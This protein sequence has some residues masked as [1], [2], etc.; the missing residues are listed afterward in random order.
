M[1][2]E[3]SRPG[4]EQHRPSDGSEDEDSTDVSETEASYAY[5]SSSSYDMGPPPTFE[6]FMQWIDPEYR[7][8][9]S[10]DPERWERRQRRR[11]ELRESREKRRQEQQ[12]RREQRRQAQ[13]R[14]LEDQVAAQQIGVHLPAAAP[15]HEHELAYEQ[16]NANEIEEIRPVPVRDPVVI[17]I[18]HAVPAPAPI[19]APVHAPVPEAAPAPVSVPEAEQ[20]SDSETDPLYPPPPAE[21]VHNQ[22]PQHAVWN[23]PGDLPVAEPSG[24]QEDIPSPVIHLDTDADDEADGDDEGMEAKEPEPLAPLAPLGAPAAPVHHHH[25]HAASAA[26]FKPLTRRQLFQAVQAW[27]REPAKARI[28]YGPIQAWDVSAITDMHELFKDAIHFNDDISTWNVGAVTNMQGMF[29][30]ARSFNQSLNA[31]DVA[32]VTTMESMFEGARSFNQ[33]LANWDVAN[34]LSMDAMFQGA[35]AFNQSLLDWTPRRLLGMADMFTDATAFHQVLE[36][37][38]DIVPEAAQHDLMTQRMR[39]DP[40]ARNLRRRL[41]GGGR[42]PRYGRHG[43]ALPLIDIDPA[44]YAAWSAFLAQQ[45]R[46]Q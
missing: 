1:G 23:A 42:A 32:Q 29:M 5:D 15:I 3:A 28:R 27:L 33:P 39:V 22:P 34:V 46:R 10:H 12:E 17:P 38:P 43:D 30:N 44:E 24:E 2:N 45:Q 4:Q 8:T 31:W 35:A 36:T 14:F 6:R 26:A 9:W 7:A 40:T 37:W 41:A 21:A 19:T 11:Q 16:G 18:H 20:D 25:H 13:Q